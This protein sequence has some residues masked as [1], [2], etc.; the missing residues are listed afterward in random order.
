M[1]QFHMKS[2]IF[3]ELPSLVVLYFKAYN[4]KEK[5][6]TAD[7]FSAEKQLLQ[8]QTQVIIPYQMHK[9]K[10]RDTEQNI[11]DRYFRNSFIIKFPD[12]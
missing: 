12:T 11:Y 8:K 2:N 4:T 1:K 5:P 10:V 7:L 3:R 9:H 6:E